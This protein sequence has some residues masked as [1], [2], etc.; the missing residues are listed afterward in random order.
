MT[1]PD[2]RTSPSL[3]D[4]VLAARVARRVYRLG[5]PRYQIA[6]ELGISRF[7]VARL[8]ALARE[9]DIVRIT[10]VEPGSV[11]TQVS[12]QL[13]ERF[14]LRRA[15]VVETTQG[16]NAAIRD[17]LG[18]AGARLL[19]EITQ[20]DDVL[21]LGW[22]RVVL[23]MAAHVT[24]LRAHKVVQ[25]SG[26]LTRPDVESTAIELVRDVA[27][28]VPAPACIFYAPMIA[29]DPEAARVMLRQQQVAEAFSSF[30]TVTKAVVGVGGWQPPASTL[31]D[32]LSAQEKKA[33]K[34]SN[35]RADL[36]GVLLDPEG[37][38]VETPISDRLITIP[39]AQLRAIPEVIGIAY[40]LE[41]VVAARAAIRGGYLDSLVTEKVF[42]EK[43]LAS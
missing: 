18:Q 28:C 3:N 35:V 8:L 32:A 4:R 5:Q 36:S 31:F 10:I 37:H 15:L 20:P 25:L 24:S 16:D 27:R 9:W 30:S 2:P 29:S 19:A 12:E 38:V 11:D 7:K 39:A 26:A 17:Q 40:G 21:G 34:G 14:D 1:E 41:K 22:A 13:R 23:A 42:A 33:M 6:A 43:L